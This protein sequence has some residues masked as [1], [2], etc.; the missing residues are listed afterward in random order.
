MEIDVKIKIW[1]N[2]VNYS[3]TSEVSFFFSFSYSFREN[4]ENKWVCASSPLKLPPSVSGEIMD[5]R[6]KE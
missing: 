1:T 6:R 2:I 5:Q 3:F 4:L